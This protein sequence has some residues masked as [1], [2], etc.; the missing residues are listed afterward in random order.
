MK[1]SHNLMIIFNIDQF[2]QPIPLYPTLSDLLEVHTR[3][4]IAS[5]HSTVSLVKILE[6]P[7]V[8]ILPSWLV[9][10]RVLEPMAIQ[11]SGI[12]TLFHKEKF[13]QNII[14]TNK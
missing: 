10:K 8:L 6:V 11:T 9:R 13:T 4:Y 12:S 5:L 7:P 2:I 14:K 1:I 3:S